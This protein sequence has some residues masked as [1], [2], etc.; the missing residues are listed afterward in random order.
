MCGIVGFVNKDGSE[1]NRE[2]LERMNRAIVHRGPDDDGSIM[3]P[4]APPEAESQAA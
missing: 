4:F 3:P 2:I 1:A